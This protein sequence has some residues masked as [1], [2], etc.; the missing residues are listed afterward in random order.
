VQRQATKAVQNLINV[1]KGEAP[2]AQVNRDV[3]FANGQ[4]S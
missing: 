2:L 4:L 3:P 1:A